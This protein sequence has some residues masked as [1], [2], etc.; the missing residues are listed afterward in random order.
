MDDRRRIRVAVGVLVLAVVVRVVLLVVPGYPADLRAYECWALRAGTE[1][2]AHIYD[3]EGPSATTG[4][5]YGYYDYP[6][7]YAYVLA[8]IG[9]LDARVR[10]EDV[11]LGFTGTPALEAAV[12]VPPL[13]ADLAL[14]G[15][16]FWCVD[17]FGLGTRSA[18]IVASLYMAQ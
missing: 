13:L 1:G 16:L 11:S 2:V 18:W 14:A 4:G 3:Y 9:A 17:R 7:L 10:P 15:L 5:E 6:P 8:P 12:K